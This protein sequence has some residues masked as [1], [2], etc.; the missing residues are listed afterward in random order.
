MLRVAHE[1]GESRIRRYEASPGAR[2]WNSPRCFLP[3]LSSWSPPGGHAHGR[4][5]TVRRHTSPL[6]RDLSAPRQRRATAVILKAFMTRSLALA[7]NALGLYAIALVL[8]VAF[9]AQLL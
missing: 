7:L 2:R 8:L 6:H 4:P 3:S 1:L 5:S 9:A